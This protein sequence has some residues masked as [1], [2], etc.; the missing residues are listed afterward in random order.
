MS[1][2]QGKIDESR[3][4]SP[5]SGSGEK[6]HALGVESSTTAPYDNVNNLRDPDE[7][8]TDEERAELVRI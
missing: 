4:I 8:C 1:N 6:P 5:D 3:G 7:G 2:F